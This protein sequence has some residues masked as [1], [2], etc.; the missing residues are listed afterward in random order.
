MAVVGNAVVKISAESAE[1]GKNVEQAKKTT[2]GF[3][4][5]LQA[6]YGRQSTLAQS[7]KLISG[8]GAFM[9]IGMA[10]RGFEH[11][12][13]TVKDITLKLHDGNHSAAEM[14]DQFA[15]AVPILGQVYSGLYDIVGAMSGVTGEIADIE[16][17][18]KFADA[19]TAA[20]QSRGKA[21]ADFRAEINKTLDDL[22]HRINGLGIKGAAK[23]LYDSD[24]E[25]DDK[26]AD[27]RKSAAD[28]VASNKEI[29]DLQKQV[30][31]ARAQLVNMPQGAKSIQ[32]LP[33]NTVMAASSMGI[34][35]DEFLAKAIAQE[36]AQRRKAYAEK[37]AQVASAEKQ[38]AD[39]KTKINDEA[40]RAIN[41]IDQKKATEGAYHFKELIIE[42]MKAAGEAVAPIMQ[43]MAD[44]QNAAIS[45]A[46]DQ[47]FDFEKQ[48]DEGLDQIQSRAK[49]LVEQTVSPYQEYVQTA[50]LLQQQFEGKQITKEQYA[51]ALGRM[52]TDWVGT[53]Y[54]HAAA[55]E[56]R[57]GGKVVQSD[58]SPADPMAT[59]NNLQ[60]KALTEQQKQTN[61]TV[62]TYNLLKGGT[63][64]V[65]DI[66]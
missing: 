43:T 39:L 22:D 21:V 42:K 2:G 55:T 47:F 27:I 26:T 29:N 45:N 18:T 8:T 24:K 48:A 52:Q 64:P 38:I 50:Q 6:Q 44:H 37:A 40:N 17:S 1:L 63:V 13:A 66:K 35:A 4:K 7:L 60:Q 32:D 25:Y 12:G 49:S 61:Y 58:K 31:E 30:N 15:R 10:A 19:I 62:L 46:L 36:D 9:A 51:G 56:S 23:D 34:G 3:F 59:L 5:S 57:L 11:L 14:A 20:M 53:G 28:K 65:V 33:G 16:A 41:E 54:Q